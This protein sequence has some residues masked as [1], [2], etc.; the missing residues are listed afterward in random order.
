MIRVLLKDRSSLDFTEATDFSIAPG[1]VLIRK[2][3]ENIASVAENE[4][5]LVSTVAIRGTIP[6]SEGEFRNISELTFKLTE[7][8]WRS[9]NHLCI[10]NF[11]PGVFQDLLESTLTAKNK[12]ENQ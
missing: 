8:R 3:E 4:I 12:P 2:G 7:L 1:S 6:L 11:A 10:E 9:C 5:L